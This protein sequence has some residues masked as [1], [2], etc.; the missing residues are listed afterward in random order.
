MHD[1]PGILHAGHV[2]QAGISR[3][4]A[5]RNG[6]F[7]AFQLWSTGEAAKGAERMPQGKAADEKAVE[8]LYAMPELVRSRCQK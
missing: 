5:N 1:Q 2:V 3:A 8:P 6:S 4:D 7:L